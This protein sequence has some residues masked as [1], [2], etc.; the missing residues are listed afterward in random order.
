MKKFNKLTKIIALSILSTIAFSSIAIGTTYALFSSTYNTNILISSSKVDVKS[1]ILEDSIQTKQLNDT[2]FTSGKNSMYSGSVSF[3]NNKINL[4]NLVPGDAVKFNIQV[5]NKSTITTKI[6][7]LIKIDNDTGLASGL[8]I[9]I[10]DEEFQ[11][12][13]I[14]KWTKTAVNEGNKTVS[15]EIELL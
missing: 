15:I 13:A 2:N 12:L 6:R 14:T 5:S 11:G 3:G 9:K 7:N 8:K 1:T 10:D 4:S